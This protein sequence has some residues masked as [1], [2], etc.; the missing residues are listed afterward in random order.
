[1][2]LAELYGCPVRSGRTV[3]TLKFLPGGPDG[4]NVGMLMLPRSNCNLQLD[5]FAAF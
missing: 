4:L 5:L 1:M 2:V 3:S